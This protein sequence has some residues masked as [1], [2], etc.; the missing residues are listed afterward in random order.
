MT[1]MKEF[2]SDFHYIPVSDF[3]REKNTQEAPYQ[4]YANGRQAIQALIAHQQWK[5]IWIPEY[6]CYDVVYS[7]RST[8]IEVVFYPDAPGVDDVAVIESLH[9][10]ENDVLLRMNYFG[11]RSFRDNSKIAVPVIEDHSHDFTG[12]WASNSNANW[13]IASLRKI[14]PMAEGGA[15]WSPKQY[16]LLANLSQTEENIVLSEKRWQAMKLKK[17]YL[18]NKLRDKDEFRA[19]YM[20]TENTFNH[21]PMS[22]I[23][24]KSKEYFEQFDIASWNKRKKE[25]WTILSEIKSDDIEILKPEE[26]DCQVFSFV[27]LLKSESIRDQVRQYLV[28]NKLYPVVLW[29]LPEEAFG[30]GLDVS[31]RMLSIPCDARYNAD[32]ILEMRGRLQ[33]TFTMII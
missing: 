31:K 6:F 33:K 3:L 28:E 27:F 1:D 30:Y 19:L 23:S 14:V 15:L 10:E 21:L 22:A 25:N 11:M 16:T 18:E 2:G 26:K 24:T 4:F 32:D 5:R 8:G 29:Q 7:I 12:V 20:E 13:C 17:K 9:F